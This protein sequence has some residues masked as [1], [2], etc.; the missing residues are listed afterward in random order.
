MNLIIQ[1][2]IT[3]HC[4]WRC[5]HCYHDDYLDEWPDLKTL[6]GIFDQIT[7]IEKNFFWPINN[8]YINFAW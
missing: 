5:K 8:K 4:N 6:K 7:S 3:E 1:W 2:H